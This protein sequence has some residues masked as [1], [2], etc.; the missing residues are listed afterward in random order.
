MFCSLTDA[1][2]SIRCTDA[3]MNFRTLEVCKYKKKI[4][5]KMLRVGRSGTRTVGCGI[6]DLVRDGYRDCHF[7][8]NRVRV[9]A[10]TRFDTPI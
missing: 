9:P 6:P 7:G 10:D 2:W 3:H 8:R 1:T 5:K 4:F